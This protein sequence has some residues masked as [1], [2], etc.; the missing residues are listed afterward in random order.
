VYNS[1]VIKNL[2]S[3]QAIC[4]ALVL[5][6]PVWSEQGAAI[7][8]G[9]MVG[10]SNGN[11]ASYE[12]ISIRLNKSAG[13]GGG[14]GFFSGGLDYRGIK[15]TPLISDAF[16]IADQSQIYGL[17]SWVESSF[18]DIQ[19]RVDSKTTE[20]WK[21]LSPDQLDKQQQ[22][23]LRSFFADRCKLKAHLETRELPV[24]DLVIVKSGLKMKEAPP[25]E[26]H[27]G[28]IAGSEMKGS[29]TAIEP[30][31]SNLATW[32]GRKVI[33][34][35]GLT[36][37]RFDFD[38]TWTPEELREA[39]PANAGPSIFTALEEQLGLKLLPSR[40]PVQVLVIDHIERPTPN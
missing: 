8:A 28:H 26:E 33:D 14:R 9:P 31:V 24:Y 36:G 16:G 34:K 25:E 2:I 22:P 4:I 10:G 3:L 32:S 39:D 38:L 12:V 40:A 35:T 11:V 29:S 18:Y 7:Q 15:L 21:S 19:A 37:K 27:G 13:G 1:S 17:P 5:S 23:M 6:V 30:L 20:A